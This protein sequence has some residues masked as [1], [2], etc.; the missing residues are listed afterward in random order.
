MEQRMGNTNTMT[1]TEVNFKPDKEREYRLFLIWLSLAPAIK[2]Q[3]EAYLD[4][5]A[6]DDENLRE[7]A[8]IRTQKQFG[9]KYG[10]SE[11]TLCDWK[12]RP[13]DEEYRELDW[14]YW[15]KKHVPYLMQ[16]LI[17]GAIEHK[18]VARIKFALES[19]GEYTQETKVTVDGTQDLFVGV[20]QLVEKLNNGHSN[21]D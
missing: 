19:A 12:Q 8:G 16:L 4:G 13:I 20:Q 3:G 21:N 11:K 7:L 1:T 15:V 6:I 18:D 9:E 17:Q 14:R 10:I 5:V 2:K